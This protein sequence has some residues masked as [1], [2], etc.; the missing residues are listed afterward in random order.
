M[1]SLVELLVE[2][3]N[4]S[5][6]ETIDTLVSEALS[7]MPGTALQTRSKDTVRNLSGED[8]VLS[9]L[10][11]IASSVT[12]DL[13]MSA[14]R[15]QLAKRNLKAELQITSLG[16]ADRFYIKHLAI[17]LVEIAEPG[18][19]FVVEE[20][21]DSVADHWEQ[22]AVQDEG[23]FS[24]SELLAT[25]S[26]VIAPFLIGLFADTAKDVFKDQAKEAI[27]SLVDRVKNRKATDNDLREM[28]R[29]IDVAIA[30]SRLSKEEK[31][32]L[33]E[34]FEIVY[35]TLEETA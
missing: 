9:Y 2:P 31:T 4:F 1:T 26:T 3:E 5:D 7:Q 28:Q 32:T 21:F 29:A 19:V 17:S 33:R 20:G 12:V 11:G 18:D 16:D 24:G 15:D 34:G 13:V 27:S 25:F 35:S 23:R 30:R 8:I 14:I 10:I 6:G 22:A